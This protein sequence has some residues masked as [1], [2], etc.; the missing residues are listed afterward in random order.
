MSSGFPDTERAREV[1][2]I[3]ARASAYWSRNSASL[4]NTGG[5]QSGRLMS[6]APS[7]SWDGHGHHP[8]RLPNGT[9]MPNSQHAPPIFCSAIAIGEN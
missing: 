7:P 4:Q 2:Y 6:V 1:Y 9:P 3:N 8:K 5:L